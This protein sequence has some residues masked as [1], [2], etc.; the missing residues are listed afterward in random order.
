MPH[1]L[2]HLRE[3]L[4][5]ENPLLRQ[6]TA[7][8]IGVCAQHAGDSLAPRVPEL[9]EQLRAVINAED[10]RSGEMHGATDNAVSAL[11]K[12]ARFRPQQVSR[13]SVMPGVLAYLPMREDAIEARLVHS[14][15]VD[16]LIS[17]DPLWVG[18]GGS[19]APQVL[20]CVA[21][22]LVL[23]NAREVAQ[24]GADDSGADDADEEGD[25]ELL[26]EDASITKLRAFAAAVR[27]NQQQATL[28]AGVVSVLAAKEAAALKALGFPSA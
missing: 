21:R 3:C 20:R 10:S 27:A 7:Y 16:G 2:P 24:N 11:L 1:L 6:P 25:D 12:L 18:A 23:H 4:A 13:D 17:G 19:Q 9:F 22:C 28:V 14:W 15:M 5:H 8:G 26:F